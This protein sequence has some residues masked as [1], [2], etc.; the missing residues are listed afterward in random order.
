MTVDKKSIWVSEVGATGFK[1]RT[2]KLQTTSTFVEATTAGFITSPEQEVWQ[3]A[4][5]D[6][7]E[8]SYGPVTAPLLAFLQPTV[9]DGVVTL[10][11][12]NA[13][14][15]TLPVV[16]NDFASF[17]GTAGALKDSGYLP[18][19]ATKTVVA[20]ASG[21]QVAN[22]IP[23]FADTTG[24]VK[25]SDGVTAISGSHLQAGLT[26]GTAGSLISCPG[27]TTTG[28]LQLTA[29]ASAGAFTSTISNRSLAQST[30]FSIGDPGQSTAS[31]LTSKVNADA[32]ANLISFSITV[33]AAA[34][35]SAASV[36]L[37]AS[38]GSKQ[39]RVQ[40]LQI[41]SGGTNFS[42]GGGDRLL[43]ITDAT[44]VYSLVPA[45]NLGTLVNARWGVG[46]PLPNAASAANNT[47]TAAGASLVAKYSGGTADYST[48]SIVINGILE[49]V[50]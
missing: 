43:S 13:G 31:I 41:N 27:T 47:L 6:I 25:S 49:R 19:D 32:G 7:V 48:G 38:S 34:L 22:H 8:M 4:P 29:V 28:T 37:Y 3:F 36:T 39:Y 45:T 26:T 20:M 18:S 15:V 42:G 30:V 5:T 23:V 14:E 16:N 33:T 40:Q 2:I 12:F 35:A 9:S 50:A 11:A 44:T 10:S 21:T 24:T 1:P 17:S 46:T